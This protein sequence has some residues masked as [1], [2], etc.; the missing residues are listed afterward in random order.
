MKTEA[1]Y[2]TQNKTDNENTLLNWTSGPKFKK[3]Y[4]TAGTARHYLGSIMG[5]GGGGKIIGLNRQTIAH[6]NMAG[7]ECTNT[8]MWKACQC[9]V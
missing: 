5:G 4:P 7:D 6:K 2:Q 3:K 8:D 9:R 1:H